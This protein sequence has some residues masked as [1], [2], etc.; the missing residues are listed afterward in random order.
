[1]NNHITSA[2]VCQRLDEQN[3]NY[4]IVELPGGF[5]IIVMELSGRIFGPYETEFSEGIYWTNKVFQEEKTF[6]KFLNTPGN[7][8]F[9][10][11]RIWLTPEFP[12]FTKE[13]KKFFDTYIVQQGIDPANYHMSKDE[14][15]NTVLESE[16][17][18]RLFEHQ[19][20]TKEMFIKKT[21]RKNENPLRYLKNYETYMK[22]VKYTGYEQEIM[23]QDI[24]PNKPMEIE[25]WNLTQVN[26]GGK[27]LVPYFGGYDYVDNYEPVDE[28]IISDKGN[29]INVN[30]QSDKDHKIGFY[31]ANTLGRAGYLMKMQ[32]TEYCLFIRN[33][34]NDPSALSVG[35]PWN[36]PG[37][38]GCSLYLYIDGGNQGGFAE[39][40]NVGKSIGGATERI[41]TIDTVNYWFYY[42]RKKDLLKIAEV[43]LGI[44]AER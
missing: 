4:R 39:F 25:M 40:E 6:E 43:L 26:P 29:Y 37:K 7:W 21:I 9:G 18:G 33:Y 8:C 16:L 38:A 34:Y 28:T 13:R 44:K 19:Y 23:L 31:A 14:F 24:S 36:Q 15:G 10:G 20:D 1:M 41:S 30:V 11:D 12:F 27:L 35:E 32:E 5:H 17:H 42:G 2:Q 22:N 3:L